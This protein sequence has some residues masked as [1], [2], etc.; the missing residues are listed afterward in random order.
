MR[1]V[2]TDRETVAAIGAKIGAEILR[3]LRPWPTWLP[4]PTPSRRE[5][6]AAARERGAAKAAKRAAR[7]EAFLR[8][9]F[10]LSRR[11]L[12]DLIWSMSVKR[13]AAC[14]GLSDNGLRKTCRRYGIPT[15]PR[16]YWRNKGARKPTKKFSR[17]RLRTLRR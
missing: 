8:Q 13:A 3:G 14:Y 5:L 9:R 2:S 11:E 10:G 17:L 12:C 1:S 15:P 7:C 4:R 6:E 16:G